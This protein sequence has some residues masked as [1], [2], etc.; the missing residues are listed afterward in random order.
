MSGGLWN[1][2]CGSFAGAG[3]DECASSCKDHEQHAGEEKYAGVL[4]PEECEDD[5]QRGDEGEG[6]GKVDDDR[7]KA[8][9][10]G[11]RRK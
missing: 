4:T 7:V 3:C 10:R 9:P 2:V 1:Q 8:V 5:Q 6:D 11:K